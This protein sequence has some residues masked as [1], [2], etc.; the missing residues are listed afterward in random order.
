MYVLVCVV[1]FFFSSRRRHTRCALVTGVQ[2]CALPICSPLVGLPAK[3]KGSFSAT[4]SLRSKKGAGR[5]ARSGFSGSDWVMMF[6]TERVLLTLAHS[7]L[8]KGSSQLRV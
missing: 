1:C 5:R 7:E 6:S 8:W 4:L 2:T 3:T